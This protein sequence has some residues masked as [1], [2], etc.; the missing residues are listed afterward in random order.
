MSG[1]GKEKTRRRRWTTFVGVKIDDE[2]RQAIAARAER[3]KIAPRKHSR[4]YRA[5]LRAG[6]VGD[7]FKT[8]GRAL[9]TL[10]ELHENLS[11]VGG[12]LNQVAH[13]L[14][15]KGHLKDKDLLAVIDELRPTVKQCYAI[16]KELKDGI[17]RRTG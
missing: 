2:L 17:V 7:T 8:W 13:W 15:A 5:L 6:L 1:G 11:R 14:N 16:V 9:D 10:D 12:N 4:L 3:E